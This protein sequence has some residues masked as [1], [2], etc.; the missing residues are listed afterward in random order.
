MWLIWS[1]KNFLGRN[2]LTRIG[3]YIPEVKFMDDNDPRKPGN[4]LSYQ[5]IADKLNEQWPH[6]N[7]RKRTRGTVIDYYNRKRKADEMR[8]RLV[9]IPRE[10]SDTLKNDDITKIIVSHCVPLGTK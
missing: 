2:R 1:A 6:F 10:I 7:L 5:Q 8:V 4:T 3:F 9:T